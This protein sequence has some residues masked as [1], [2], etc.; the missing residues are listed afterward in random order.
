M[1]KDC[2]IHPVEEKNLLWAQVMA[3]HLPLWWIQS[4]IR[5]ILDK[6]DTAK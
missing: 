2:Q 1:F 4:V 3:R 6:K 5:Y